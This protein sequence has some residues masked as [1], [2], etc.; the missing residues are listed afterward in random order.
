MDNPLLSILPAL[1]P[2][3][4]DSFRLARN[5]GKNSLE[6]EAAGTLSSGYLFTSDQDSCCTVDGRTEM[7][8]DS[9]AAG[10]SCLAIS[11]AELL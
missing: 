4:K 9:A 2:M 10:M 7:T 8:P 3:S 1:R 6:P 5:D 11:R